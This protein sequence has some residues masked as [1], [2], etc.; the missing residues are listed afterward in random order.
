MWDNWFLRHLNALMC[1]VKYS[2]LNSFLS[3]SFQTLN[4]SLK[5]YF[6]PN[7]INLYFLVKLPAS[8]FL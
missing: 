4:F 1:V 2:P 7:I 3:D 8:N 6:N 5:I